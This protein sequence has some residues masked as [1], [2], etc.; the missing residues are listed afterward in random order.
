MAMSF[1]YEFPHPAVTVDFV[2]FGVD[3]SDPN[4]DLRV[5]LV[6][7]ADEPFKGYFALPGGFVNIDED[8]DDAAKRMLRETTGIGPRF[9]MEQL[10]TFGAPDR[11]P[12]ERVITVAYLALVNIAGRKIM[13]VSDA[14]FVAWYPARWRARLAFDHRKI[15]DAAIE[16]LESKV[17]YAPVGFDLLPKKFTLGELQRLYEVIL[18]RS[19]DTRNFRKR[20]AEMS[21]LTPTGEKK[22]T[23]GRK[24]Q[25]FSFDKAAYDSA[26]KRGFNFEV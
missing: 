19:L 14:D 13:A 2:I 16:R 21:I 23:G 1:T 9:Y 15:L 20:I 26:I 5:L 12:R 25:L 17:R 24:A 8:L 10:R 6:Q 7:R 3:L 4:P 11:D 22:P 18:D